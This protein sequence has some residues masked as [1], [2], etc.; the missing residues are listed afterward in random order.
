MTDRYKVILLCDLEVH[1]SLTKEEIVCGQ[2]DCIEEQALQT[3]Q[4]GEKSSKFTSCREQSGLP[5]ISQNYTGNVLH[6]AQSLR[7]VNYTGWLFSSASGPVR[8]TV[9]QW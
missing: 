4:C 2:G 6:Y 1:T 3:T 5:E 9:E 8:E 7:M